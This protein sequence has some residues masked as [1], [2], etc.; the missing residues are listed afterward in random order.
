MHCPFGA[1]FAT[2]L[3][4]LDPTLTVMPIIEIALFEMH[5]KVIVELLEFRL[6]FECGLIWGDVEIGKIQCTQTSSTKVT[7]SR[8]DK[9]VPYH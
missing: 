5:K 8:H 1:T 9:H 7:R 2:V 3:S 4:L 6:K